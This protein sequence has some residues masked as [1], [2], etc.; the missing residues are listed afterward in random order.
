MVGK[1]IL[2]IYSV[3][4]LT[5]CAAQGPTSLPPHFLGEWRGLSDMR[6]SY[7][8]YDDGR[9]IRT[10]VPTG[11]INDEGLYKVLGQDDA[12]N[13]YILTREKWYRPP[14]ERYQYDYKKL[15]WEDS[16]F[17]KPSI[18]VMYGGLITHDYTQE[19]WDMP[20]AVHMQK[21][22]QQQKKYPKKSMLGIFNG[23]ESYIR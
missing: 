7:H 20:A 18:G 15:E 12:N 21:I 1:I 9:Y 13:I 11:E 17:S 10:Y 5:A 22:R 3:F 2:A 19:D 23:R 4:L 16:M 6:F 8:F 14:D